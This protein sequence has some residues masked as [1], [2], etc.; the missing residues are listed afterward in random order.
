MSLA[1]SPASSSVGT[2]MMVPMSTMIPMPTNFI[3]RSRS[4][5]GTGPGGAD[6]SAF[7]IKPKSLRPSRSPCQIV[8]SERTRL[9]IPP[10]A[11]A[12]EP[13]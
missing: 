11:T 3:E 6:S 1:P 4:V 8:G 5:L 12:P 9:T 13:M 2:A 10:A 7:G